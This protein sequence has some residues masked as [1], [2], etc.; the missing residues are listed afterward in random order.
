MTDQ[1]TEVFQVTEK[2][3]KALAEFRKQSANLAEKIVALNNALKETPE[4]KALE[5]AQNAKKE[6]EENASFL[7]GFIRKAAL[8]QFNTTKAK[9]TIAGVT[10]KIFKLLRY[11][12]AAAESWARE[13]M[14]EL[15]KLD[16][17]GFEKYAK[18]VAD[19]VPVPCVTFEEDP[20]VEISSDLSMYLEA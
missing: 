18:A 2:D 11:E 13:K 4:F 1:I 12:K 15:F 6:V 16:E 8:E 20:R 10:V 7:D 9:P 14:P 3:L 5:A 17:K 19:T